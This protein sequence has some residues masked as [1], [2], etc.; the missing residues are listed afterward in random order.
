MKQLIIGSL[1]GGLLLFLW[2][3]LSWSILNVHGNQMKYTDKQD[4]ILKVLS[5][6]LKEGEYFLPTLPPGYSSEQEQTYMAE[7]EGKPW[8]QVSYHPEWK[9]SMGSNMAR[10]FLIDFLAVLLLCWILSRYEQVN[11][12]SALLT[13]LSVGFIGF[14]TIVYLDNIWFETKSLGYL[15]DA[16]VSW[17][18]V[19][20]WLGFYLKK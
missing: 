17:G 18:L 1:I 15:I 8:A 2:Q 6:N 5:E 13:S 7:L 4:E 16:V 11:F 19:G 10:A 9:V 12:V 14:L 20:A 3:F